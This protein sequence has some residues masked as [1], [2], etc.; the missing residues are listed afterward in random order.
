[1]GRGCAVGDGRL[2]AAWGVFGVHFLIHP[3]PKTVENHIE[4]DDG[5]AYQTTCFMMEGGK[6]G[7]RSLDDIKMKKKSTQT[8]YD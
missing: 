1:V 4:H 6:A 5:R 7:R 8:P 2:R 3:T